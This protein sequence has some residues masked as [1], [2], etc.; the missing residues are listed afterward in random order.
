MKLVVSSVLALLLASTAAMADDFCSQFRDTKA[1]AELGCNWLDNEQ[2]CVDPF[3]PVPAPRGLSCV[4][5]SDPDSC[6]DMDG[7]M[8]LD[9]ICFELGGR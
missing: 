2:I 8:W 7:C 6:N 3:A 5:V 4:E 9:G 1:C